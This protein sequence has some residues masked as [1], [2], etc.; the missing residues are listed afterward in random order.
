ML[1]SCCINTYKRPE[2]LKKLILSLEN[3]ELDSDINL[4]II[5]VDNDNEKQAES[6]INEL[7]Q[8]SRHQIKYFNQPIKNISLTRNKAVAE[9]TGKLIFFIDDDGYADKNWITESIKCLRK[10]DA[11]AVFGKVV[12]YFEQGVDKWLKDGP[13]F[14]R[15]FQKTGEIS[16]FKRTG[17]CVIKAEMIKSLIHPF[18]PIFGL[19]GGEDVN[20][21]TKL[22]KKG[23]KFIFC[24]EAI[25]FDFVPLERANLRWLTRRSF[26]AGITY[27][28]GIISIS[29]FK[30]GRIVFELMKGILY[31][32][33]SIILVII[34]FYSKLYRIQWFLKI[35]SNLGHIAAVFN[36]R[37]QEYK[38]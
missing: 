6:V 33:I 15:I 3:Q 21:F 9:A 30:L 17:N 11:D 28:D 5:V 34:T 16:K 31:L 23:A 26:R 36:M 25:V 27:T 12:P 24:A 38:D 4:E 8:N 22:E 19:T 2:L 14:K 37:Y 10:Y 1:C 29:E 32:L 20:L 13:F 18:D 35:I 7:Q